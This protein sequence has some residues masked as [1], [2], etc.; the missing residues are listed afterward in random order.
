MKGV[1]HGY[2]VFIIVSAIL[3]GGQ[4]IMAQDIGKK[5][6]ME[7]QKYTIQEANH[8]FAVSLNNLVWDLLAK[9]ERTRD[10]SE[11]MVNAANASF[12]HWSVVGQPVNFARG[13]WL[14]SHVY[15]VLKQGGQAVYFADRCMETTQKA[16]L[17]DFDLAYAFEG[18]A[19]AYAA[20]GDVERSQ[21]NWQKAQDAGE[22]IKSQED[23]DLF[24]ND[25]KAEPWFGIR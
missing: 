6:G 18:L 23:R 19:R 20:S 10:E 21:E 2:A 12:Y 7:E 15:A 3:I 9:K 16:G 13:Y 11:R 22:K 1:A 24:F 5:E 25:F 8:Y 4:S 17:I 14:I